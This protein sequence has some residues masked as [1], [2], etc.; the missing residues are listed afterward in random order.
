M[1]CGYFHRV[2]VCICACRTGVWLELCGGSAVHVRR[3]LGAHEPHVSKPQP[4]NW[5]NQSSSC[6][7][8]LGQS[9]GKADRRG[10]AHGSCLVLGWCWLR[11]GISDNVFGLCTDAATPGGVQA[12]ATGNTGMMW[13]R[14]GVGMSCAFRTIKINPREEDSNLMCPKLCNLKRHC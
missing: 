7:R 12:R 9:C 6:T 5:E 13:I 1:S 14:S 2:P 11:C 8:E 4:L 3:I 10:R